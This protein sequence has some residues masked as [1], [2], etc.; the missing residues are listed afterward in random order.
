MMP[1]TVTRS[2]RNTKQRAQ[3]AIIRE[4]ALK[5]GGYIPNSVCAFEKLHEGSTMQSE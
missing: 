2:N 5:L 1:V 4:L 3:W